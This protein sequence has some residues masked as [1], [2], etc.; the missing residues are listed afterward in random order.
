MNKEIEF[1]IGFA[2]GRANV[3]N[4]INTYYKNMLEQIERYKEKV[5]LTIYILMDTSYQSTKMKDFYKLLPEI[6]NSEI[7]IKYITPE[8]IEQE[9]LFLEEEGHL[10]IEEATKLVGHGYAKCRNTLLYYALRDKMDYLLFWDDDEY[11]VASVKKDDGSIEWKDQDNILIHLENIENAD[12]TIGYHCGYISP[13]PFVDCKTEI[14]EEMLKNYIEAVSNDI[15]SWENIK[16]RFDKDNGVTFANEEIASGRGVKEINMENGG[17]WI[18]GSTLCLNLKHI[19]KIPAFYNP[20]GA[21]GED[22]FFATKLEKAKV[23]KVPIYHFH[24]GF[25]KYTQIMQGEYPKKLRKIACKE[26]SIPQR[27]LRASV[28][29]IKYKPLFTYITNNQ[30]YDTIMKIVEEDLKVSVP[31]MN[32]IFEDENLD[33]NIVLKEFEKYCSNVKNDYEEYNEINNIWNKVK[34]RIR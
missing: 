30:Q 9:K 2:T 16:E 25:L 6:Y 26:D 4:I 13:I 17:K 23:L 20:L 29:W 27:F 5:H 11:P 21:R 22:T 28:G 15:I 3:C 1:A 14:N 24:D 34:N 18:A 19:E 8:V 31:C 7:D 12:V 10:T 33:F 32:K